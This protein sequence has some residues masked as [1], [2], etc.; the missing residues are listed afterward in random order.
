MSGDL[1]GSEHSLDD[2]GRVSLSCSMR[3][4]NQKDL[5]QRY[6]HDRKV[7]FPHPASPS[8][9]TVTVVDSV[10]WSFIAICRYSLV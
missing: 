9:K 6:T 3:C 10:F 7:D 2:F 4:R 8:N 5:G 1:V